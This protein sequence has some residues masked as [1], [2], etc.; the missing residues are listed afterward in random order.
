VRR[1][2]GRERRIIDVW[3]GITVLT[4]PFEEPDGRSM[5]VTA[6][7]YA[8][9]PLPVQMRVRGTF[10]VV[11]FESPEEGAAMLPYRHIEGYT[12]VL[13]PALRIGGRVF[14]SQEAQ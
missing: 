3:N 9:Q 2:L 6:L 10:S 13:L 14:L 4:A 1:S 5:L 8:Y 11:Q 7:N 12:E